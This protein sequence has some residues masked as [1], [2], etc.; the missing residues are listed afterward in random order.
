MPNFLLRLPAVMEITGL[1][2]SEI[3]KRMSKEPPEFPK[4]V[5]LGP[6]TVAWVKS[7]I[8]A[9]V[10]KQIRL[11][12]GG[13]IATAIEQADGLLGGLDGE[14]RNVSTISMPTVSEPPMEPI[15]T[16]SPRR[17]H[18]LERIRRE[19]TRSPREHHLN[20]LERIR[21]ENEMAEAE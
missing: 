15:K 1:C 4:A 7:E 8:D 2:R 16:R 3:Y 17:E 21:R 12:R 9:W 18:H 19:N 20:E 11:A 6:K 5:R 14:A 10:E 13:T